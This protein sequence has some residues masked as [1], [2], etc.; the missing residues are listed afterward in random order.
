MLAALN[1][2]QYDWRHAGENKVLGLTNSLPDITTDVLSDLAEAWA[3]SSG[4]VEHINVEWRSGLGER[5]AHIALDV[6]GGL[7]ETA[8]DALA[9]QLRGYVTQDRNKGLNSGFDLAARGGGQHA[10]LGGEYICRL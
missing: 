5:R 8:D 3:Q 10:A 1:G 7:R 6:V 9:W 2:E 4:T